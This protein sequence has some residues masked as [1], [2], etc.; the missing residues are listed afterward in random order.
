MRGRS[1]VLYY[2]RQNNP[3]GLILSLLGCF[4]ALFSTV[5]KADQVSERGDKL[6][7]SFGAF[8]DTYYAYD[9]NNP[10]DH[11]V[12]LV[13]QSKRNN[14]FNINLAFVDTKVETNK[15]RGRLA[16]QFGTSVE[17]NYAN[18]PKIG[19]VSGPKLS[20]N[21]QEARVGYRILENLWIDAGIYFSYIGFEG[22]ISRDNWNYTRSLD[23]ELTPYYESGVKAT[24]QC[25][26][27]LAIQLHVM[28]GWGVVSEN[29][30]NKSLGLQVAFSP[31]PNYSLVYNSFLG[32]ELDTSGALGRRFFNQIIG[33]AS[34]SAA[35]QL[36]LTYDV[37]MQRS[38]QDSR[39]AYWRNATLL[40]KY[41]LNSTM[42]LAFRAET[43]QDPSQ[44]IVKT[45]T[46]NGLQA[47]G[48][49]T[50]IDIQLDPRLVWRMEY[51]AL[52][53]SDP[54]FAGKFTSHK[55]D[56]LMVT[57]LAMTI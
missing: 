6:P 24:Y 12:N 11:E 33:R 10:P 35:W 5:A 29:N 23:A 41:K 7:M 8:I 40:A 44:V 55:M 46:P 9:P 26:D 28:N 2:G 17:A 30:L 42:D 39:E 37:G 52:W 25:T 54:V 15:I 38:L 20:Q 31:N 51:R 1:V 36:A 14:E 49:A 19:Q 50:N 27:D 18:E 4:Y 13:T 43:Y 3:G 22:F 48:L 32:N 57:S 53:A 34:I 16:L 45:T 56:P 21:I 47:R